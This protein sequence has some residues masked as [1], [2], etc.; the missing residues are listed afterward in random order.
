MYDYIDKNIYHYKVLEKLGGGGMGVVYKAKDT[1]LDRYAALKFLPPH[2]LTD[3][4]AKQ[5]FIEEAKTASSLDHP[6]IC[7]IYDIG[8][9]DEGQIFIAMACYEG[10]T[11]KQKL[12]KG[13]L[14][15]DEA[16]GITIQICR[17][18]IRAHENNIT[19]RDIKPANIMIT[20]KGEVKILDFGLAKQRGKDSFTKVGTTVGTTDYMSPEQA[21]GK[22]VDSRTD[23]WSI[24][25]ILHEMLTGELP[26]KGEYD[27]AVIFSILNEE[28][29]PVSSKR[30]NVPDKLQRI[31]NR[32]LKKNKDERYSSVEE[33]LSELESLR[34]GAKQIISNKKN[35][36]FSFKKNKKLLAAFGSVILL[37]AIIF[38]FFI[39]NEA[40]GDV[41]GPIAVMEFENLQDPEDDRRLGQIV[42]E[43]LITDLS[44][45]HTVNLISS[46]RLYDLKK[47]LGYRDN[48]KI[49]RDMSMEI[50]RRAEADKMLTGNVIKND[51]KW[52]LTGLV[53]NVED[54]RIIG[55]KK[56]VGEDFYTMIDRLSAE[57]YEE[58]EIP[59]EGPG[60]GKI[61][62]K[63]KTTSSLEAYNHYLKGNELLNDFQ[64]EKAINEYTQAIEID[65]G[66]SKAYYKLASAFW[67]SA[68]EL[69]FGTDLKKLEKA[70]NTLRK[71]LKSERYISELLR[72]QID[73]MLSLIEQD[74]NKA[75]EIY[76]QA[77]KEYPQE[78]EFWYGLGEA[79][80]HK[81]PPEDLK[82]MDAFDRSIELDNSFNIAYRH[83]FGIYF[84]NR[85]FDRGIEKLK[86]H[87]VLFP[88]NETGYIELANFFRAK[89]E[90]TSAIETLKDAL[91]KFP[92]SS[93][94]IN[95]LAFT[96]Q[97]AGEY[98]KAIETNR[99]ILQSSVSTPAWKFNALHDM[100]FQSGEIGQYSK[101][102]EYQKRALEE[103][104]HLGRND[105]SHI[106]ID[107]SDFSRLLGKYEDAIRYA[108]IARDL[109]RPNNRF[110][111][112]SRYLG[113]AYVETGQYDQLEKVL[114]SIKHYAEENNEQNNWKYGYDFLLIEKFFS[115]NE[116]DKA[117]EIFNNTFGNTEKIYHLYYY[118]YHL[119]KTSIIYLSKKNYQKVEEN[120]EK[121]REPTVNQGIR[122]Y[123][124][125]RSFYIEGLMHEKKGNYSLA[126][127]SYEKFLEI[128]KN[129]DPQIKE[130]KEVKKRLNLLRSDS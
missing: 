11:L 99:K 31:I 129:A 10:E 124:Y 87:I 98:Q 86:E 9:T 102:L 28:P 69:T 83:I 56:I 84:I 90:H 13:L 37:I 81:D 22:G 30:E 75:L 105:S 110:F 27:Q 38:F 20:N 15:I 36:V 8:E 122:W 130:L 60:F 111:M 117:L 33:L 66:F 107:M 63:E 7:T 68:S 12:K 71:V 92:E 3:E 79:Y 29:E 96:Y 6:N 59:S 125:P 89:S 5:R 82:A 34:N 120:I 46:Q 39:G 95:R 114:E 25:V 48:K 119:Y 16:L 21:A 76:K 108:Q 109:P 23:I 116:Y 78:K 128:W 61:P 58:F 42:Q 1:K 2:L 32:C 54:G 53:I 41:E 49:T 85:M 52:I 50:A 113:M 100:A 47:Q 72:S 101:G 35:E 126:L 80:Y 43:L 19:H 127:K 44:S 62:V 70:E 17:G 67:W 74:Y 14:D 115:V 57:L 106:Y 51:N 64:L 103:A 77:V 112:A 55:S 45:V 88:E 123:L 121:M 91:N 93:R 73:G 97:Y 4:E 18:I 65:S 24:G 26:F 40:A 94:I 118:Q 104:K